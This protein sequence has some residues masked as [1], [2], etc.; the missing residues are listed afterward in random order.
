MTKQLQGKTALVTGGT[1]G[2]GLATATLFRDQGAKVIV[3]GRSSSTIESA[4]AQLGETVS[5]VQSDAGDPEAITNLVAT[6]SKN[7][8][9]VDILFIN[10]GIARFAPIA[11]LSEDNLD[12]LL[13]VNFKGPFL[14]LQA[15]LP[16]L[17]KGSSVLINTSITNRKG[18]PGA[19]VYAASKAA[20]RSLVRTAAAELSPLGIRVN[21]IS[22]GPISTPIYD[23]L[24]LS[25]AETEGFAE[26]VV[27]QV[28]L[29]R[30]GHPEELAQAALFLASD[31]SSY[32]QGVEL[33]VDGGMAQI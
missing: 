9:R 16:L 33:Q 28:P 6:I 5:V 10:A 12:E 15:T 23:K 24:G 25:K 11:A 4:R 1:S 13:R 32:V 2:I 27:K 20:L 8:D 26:S 19:S 14:L 7:T 29:G 18:M 3:T 22:P 21:A 31:A 30:F 17:K